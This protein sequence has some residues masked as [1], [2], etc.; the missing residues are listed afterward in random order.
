MLALALR[1][2]GQRFH[3]WVLPTALGLHGLLWS[4]FGRRPL[5]LG[6]CAA[7]LV[8]VVVAAWKRRNPVPIASLPPLPA[9][10]P[11]GA[12]GYG[13]R[14]VSAGGS[15]SGKPRLALVPGGTAIGAP[16]QGAELSLRAWTEAARSAA[17]SEASAPRAIL[18]GGPPLPPPEATVPS[19]EVRWGP[20]DEAH[21]AGWER[22]GPGEGALA[23]SP[24]ATLPGISL[25]DSLW[26]R[27]DTRQRAELWPQ[28]T[29]PGEVVAAPVRLSQVLAR[30]AEGW[31]GRER[32]AGATL[33]WEPLDVPQGT[34]VLV[35]RAVG[36]G[37]P[38]DRGAVLALVP[39]SLPGVKA[40]G[41]GRYAGRGVFVP[42]HLLLP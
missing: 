6:A 11:F 42:L 1:A 18:V 26:R 10:V 30:P 16:Q 7:F 35:L 33:D 12:A 31:F 9:A 3:W 39:T 27:A 21:A 5:F 28:L 40:L 8:A 24:G 22:G 14:S 20:P 13:L 29:A 15:A 32:C 41:P 36:P 4:G 37:L 19:G 25:L 34:T 38:G 17:A 23:G 2:R